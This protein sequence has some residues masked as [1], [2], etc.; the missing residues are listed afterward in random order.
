MKVLISI[1]Q[2]CQWRKTNEVKKA[3]GPVPEE[4]NS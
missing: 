3:S 4:Q 1:F 2:N